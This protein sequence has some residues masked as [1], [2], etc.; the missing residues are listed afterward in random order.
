[1][2]TESRRTEVTNDQESSVR[3]KSRLIVVQLY[4]VGNDAISCIT[5]RAAHLSLSY[6][7]MQLIQRRVNSDYPW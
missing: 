6:Y 1:M 4:N 3:C 2:E 5:L 7:R